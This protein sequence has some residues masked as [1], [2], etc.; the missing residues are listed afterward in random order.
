M[1][2]AETFH[3]PSKTV[4]SL[5]GFRPSSSDYGSNGPVHVS[6]NK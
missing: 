2:K 1:K 3:K 5:F 6:F 4:A